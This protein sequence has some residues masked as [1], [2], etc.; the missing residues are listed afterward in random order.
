MPV[1]GGQQE[2]RERLGAE[3][4]A[5]THAAVETQDDQLPPVQ[6]KGDASS[7]KL[8]L[9]GEGDITQGL[10]ECSYTVSAVQEQSPG[11]PRDQTGKL[12]SW[13]N[14]WGTGEW[15]TETVS[16]VNRILESSKTKP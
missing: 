12:R 9:P 1:L 2:F 16:K 5:N 4:W 11:W 14:H 8:T 7:R 10:C 3:V 13:G 6:V 15:T